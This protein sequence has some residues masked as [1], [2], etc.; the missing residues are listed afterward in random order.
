LIVLLVL[1][2][3]SPVS[4][5]VS[6][7]RET[8]FSMEEGL[9]PVL[10]WM[11][12]PSIPTDRSGT[13]TEIVFH[14]L[15][16]QSFRVVSSGETAEIHP[17]AASNIT[18]NGYAFMAAA[19]DFLAYGVAGEQTASHALSYK[20]IT[21]DFRGLS[22]QSV[23][24]SVEYR[25]SLFLIAGG[26]DASALGVSFPV[27]NRFRIGPAY[28]AGRHGGNLWL[29]AQ[30]HSG[31][32]GVV[33]FPAIDETTSYRRIYG[34]VQFGGA[35]FVYGW[36]GTNQFSRLSFNTG[37]LRTELSMTVPGLMVEYRPAESILLLGSC[38]EKGWLQGEIQGEFHGITAGADIV[39]HPG[40]SYSWGF[41]AGITMGDNVLDHQLRVEH[42]W[43]AENAVSSFKY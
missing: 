20:N 25:D 3:L 29:R 34:T 5:V 15:E 37:D 14:G 22:F 23:H 21:V 39:R 40:G 30:V 6:G 12:E 8:A 4:G 43:I 32:F 16:K 1:F 17:V 9:L 31:P 42:P 38:G 41:S 19:G 35:Q 11:Y 18:Q 33:T 10:L 36:N 27:G 26:R 7:G 13:F 2:S 24:T 28:C